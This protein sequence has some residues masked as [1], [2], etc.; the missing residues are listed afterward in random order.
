MYVQERR[1]RETESTKAQVGRRRRRFIARLLAHAH[2]S[3][4]SNTFSKRKQTEHALQSSL[5]HHAP[6]QPGV[7]DC[8]S[9]VRQVARRERRL[10]GVVGRSLAGG[11]A[12]CRERDGEGKLSVVCVRARRS[13]TH[14]L[15]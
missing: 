11:G 2:D 1:A 12:I 8:L 14:A 7:L 5:N 15:M 4:S 9:V 13:A 3:H 6:E 10:Q